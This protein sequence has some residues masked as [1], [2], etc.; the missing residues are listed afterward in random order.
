MK[1]IKGLY[2]KLACCFLLIYT[3]IG[4]FLFPVPAKNILNETIR[5]LYFHVPMWFAMMLVFGFSVYH[6]IQFLSKNDL[7]EDIKSFEYI[8]TGI[9]FGIGGLITGSIWA[10]YTWG[11]W[12]VFEDPK[13]NGAAVVM[14]EYCA[15]FVLRASI[16]DAYNKAKISAIYNIFAA[17]SMIPLL[18]I[19]PRLNSSLHPGNGGNPGF[20]AYDLDKSLR[21]VFYPAAAGWMLLSYWIA[22]N[23][24]RISLLEEKISQSTMKETK[25]T[26]TT[27]ENNNND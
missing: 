3:V 13:L 5:N 23:R 1:L 26:L 7:K 6:A 14:L 10:K 25:S 22:N 12:W 18:F 15:Y 20:N 21:M 4:G 2:W 11:A 9:Y 24:L 16:T 17:V 19:L 8:N 27:I